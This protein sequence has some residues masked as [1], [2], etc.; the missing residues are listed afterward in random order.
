MQTLQEPDGIHGLPGHHPAR[1]FVEQLARQVELSASDVAR[2]LARTTIRGHNSEITHIGEAVKKALCEYPGV[3]ELSHR[4]VDAIAEAVIQLA[5]DASG[6]TLRG[7][8]TDLFMPG[9]DLTRA[10]SD[11]LIA[12]KRIRKADVLAVIDRCKTA[13]EDGGHA[14]TTLDIFETLLAE[15][16]KRSFSESLFSYAESLSSYNSRSYSLGDFAFE[17]AAKIYVPVTGRQRD[18]GAGTDIEIGT[19]AT[20]LADGR[21]LLVEGGPGSGKSTILR[22]MARCAWTDPAQLG[23]ERKHIAF[24]IK[25][26]FLAEA[27]GVAL[28]DRLWS[29]LAKTEPREL[30]IGSRPP[31]GFLRQWPEATG[32]PWLFL[33]DGYDEV[34]AE[35]AAET[36]EWMLDLA[37]DGNKLVLSSRP[38]ALPIAAR[39]NFSTLELRPFDDAQQRRLAQAW[40]GEDCEDFLEAF[41]KTTSAELGGTPLLVTI[42]ASVFRKEGELPYRRSELYRR[43][44]DI[45]LKEGLKRAAD[46]E[47][48]DDLRNLAED[49][50]PR[51]LAILARSMSEIQEQATTVDFGNDP[52]DLIEGMAEELRRDLGL[53]PL[54][55]THRSKQLFEFLGRRS[56]VLRTN[57]NEFEWLHPTFREYFT[58]LSFANEVNPAAIS[59]LF[60]QAADPSWRQVILFLL[61]IKS[62]DGSVDELV[63]ELATSAVPYGAA[64]AG[65]AVV[66]GADVDT[67][68]S[69]AVIK[70]ICDAIRQLGKGWVCERLLTTQSMEI[71][72]LRDA[73]SLLKDYPGGAAAMEELTGDLERLAVSFGRGGASATEDLFELQAAAPL[74]R[75]AAGA[76]NPIP[77][78]L[79]AAASLDKL[80]YQEKANELR[81]ALARW[82]SKDNRAAWPELVKT[83]TAVPELLAL[84]ASDEHFSSQDWSD[85]LDAIEEDK[86]EELFQF[87]VADPRPTDTAKLAIRL[88]ILD[89]APAGMAL[90]DLVKGDPPLL[91]ACLAAIKRNGTGV[92]LLSLVRDETLTRNIRT[93]SLRILRDLGDADGLVSLV[94]DDTIEHVLRRRAAEAASAVVLAPEQAATLFT[95]FDRLENRDKPTILRRRAQLLYQADRP[96]EALPLFQR[97]LTGRSPTITMRL[98]HAHCLELVGLDDEALQM[99]VEA[100]RLM[101]GLIYANCRRAL[102]L[103]AKS[104]LIE[105]ADVVDKVWPDQAPDWFFPT[106][107]LILKGAFRPDSAVH[108]LRDQ[109]WVEPLAI[110]HRADLSLDKG[111]T[112]TAI[113]QL[114]ELTTREQDE[115][116]EFE[117][118][119]VLRMRG[120]LDQALQQYAKLSERGDSA[121]LSEQADVLI[122]L[123][124]FPEAEVC[125]SS[126]RRD[127][128]DDVFISYLNGLSGAYQ[129]ESSLLFQAA[130][131]GLVATA[132]A[133]E[134]EMNPTSVSNRL[135]FA[136]V[137]SDF[138]RA[139]R[140]MDRL[141]GECQY[142]HLRAY[143]IPYL[144][145]LSGALG[146]VPALRSLQK[147]AIDFAWPTGWDADDPSV[148]R[149]AALSEI[150]RNSHPFPMYCQKHAIGGLDDDARLGE[151]I[152]GAYG[153]DPRSLVMWTIGRPDRLYAHGNFL[154][155]EGAQWNFKFCD[156]TQTV[157]RTNLEVLV[158][159]MGVKRFM[160]VQDD[161][162][163][164]FE[165]AAKRSRL[166]VECVI[167]DLRL[168]WFLP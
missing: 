51:Y 83:M 144:E 117:I 151:R 79:D 106:A 55:A 101:P 15:K 145:T 14:K 132:D 114:R 112:N 155:D 69:D 35:V 26:R 95:Y 61:A 39:P 50:L 25:M 77:L 150:R 136:L 63:E 72:P 110:F 134:S 71:V 13:P 6:K 156:E 137:K 116:A 29:A 121:A 22:E 161:L 36:L 20:L 159:G 73:I 59:A 109:D 30:T 131:A 98:M 102:I 162:R 68:V 43:F 5:R 97:W 85:V 46:N 66:E 74:E 58:A 7:P 2:T 86:R 34:G 28:E 40:L 133:M 147:S 27:K 111:Y 90:L 3:T 65:V 70:H 87:L 152:Q 157:L 158:N 125:L 166:S 100:E 64:L 19:G 31:P 123:R 17:A 135:L 138:A 105:A 32:A 76:D 84:F 154:K 96:S 54:M 18:G 129:G 168:G 21:S 124:R 16:S 88:R 143:T 167:A 38:N 10:H 80:G 94:A 165:L 91:D 78:R 11:Q 8:I 139:G 24:P 57:A 127:F 115:L 45:V 42:A 164:Q 99:Y 41:R 118:G 92:E 113:K 148:L 142:Q 103:F 141:I 107:F 122:R 108:W 52:Q 56:G 81:M 82:V 62:K 60:S 104:R 37:R 130:E 119:Q 126:L 23:L 146:D 163:M 49:H 9:S 153:P 44:V 12:G 53:P 75:L 47:L 160:F 89:S 67:P 33:I 128:P 1:Q 48:E 93:A 140:A 120:D 149:R 4:V